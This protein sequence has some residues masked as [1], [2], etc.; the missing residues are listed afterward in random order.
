V[1]YDGAGAQTVAA[2][3]Y[4]YLRLTNT[5]NKTM[6][7]AVVVG[8]DLTIENASSLD[9]STGNFSL[10]VR[11]SWLVTSTDP[12]P[13]REQQGRVIFSGTTTTQT[14]SNPLLAET[15]YR[16]TFQGSSTL[17]PTYDATVDF[18]V[19]SAVTFTSGILQMNGYDLTL[20]MTGVNSIF[21][22]GKIIS[23][24]ATTDFIV[25]DPSTALLIGFGGTQFG[26]ATIGLTI[27]V[28]AGNIR[29]DGSRFYGVETFTKTGITRDDCNGGNVFYGSV[30]FNTVAGKERWR[31]AFLRPDTFYNASIIHFGISDLVF[32]YQTTGNTFYGN[33]AIFTNSP[34]GLF[35]TSN[36]GT[37]NG[38]CTFKGAVNV[39][40]ALSGQVNFAGGGGTITQ[41]C[42]FESTIRC[43][44]TGTSTGDVR[45]GG[46]NG[47]V[48]LTPTA[49]FIAGTVAGQ[50]QILLI[51]VTQNGTLM[52]TITTTGVNSL[53]SCG[54]GSIPS[55][56]N[57]PVTFTTRRLI[58]SAAFYNGDV[59]FIITDTT[60]LR[61]N[62]FNGL[63]NDITFTA[64]GNIGGSNGANRFAA[65][66][67]TTIR[68][69]SPVTF[70]W[71][72]FSPDDFNGDV[73]F[74]QTGSG[75]L[76]PAENT[77][78]PTTF[79]GNVSTLG[80]TAAVTFSRSKFDGSTTQ[81]IT[82]PIAFP[83]RFTN[84]E[85]ASTATLP[86]VSITVNN[87]VF[88]TGTV[89]LTSGTVDLNGNTLT[90]G[91][92]ANNT[93]TLVHTSGYFFNGTFRRWMNGSVLNMGSSRGLFPMGTDQNDY[94]PIWVAYS[95][96][97]N[98]GGILLVTHNANYPSLATAITPYTDA[99]WGNSVVGISNSNWRIALNNGF[100]LNGTSGSVRF[101]GDGFGT[102]ALA[103]LNASL[104]TTTVGTYSAA[105]NAVV[106]LEVTRTGLTTANLIRTWYI[107][108][109]NIAAS[110]LPVSWLDFTA[111]AGTNKVNLQWTT[112]SE[113][114][115][116]Y[117]LVQRS[118]DGVNFESIGTV[119][120]MG[121]SSTAQNY[122][123]IDTEPLNG[124]V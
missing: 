105:T 119:D 72:F 112:A 73:T 34:G 103:D 100:A 104:A 44:S 69:A 110:P 5:G 108:T 4:S 117:F 66:T 114:N 83:P 106:P 78:L 122:S 97:L 107:G 2:A 6:A 84:I 62:K 79:S 8:K 28:T 29:F 32:G 109:R 30:T 41:N 111:E 75:A 61:W 94:R 123:F 26:D 101:G 57:G 9:V 63:V 35:F 43:N 120:G 86:S 82:G 40:I 11:G 45:F 23:N 64:T 18:I 60:Q 36:V 7:G 14:I 89:R 59:T 87:V 52:Q 12:D 116:D 121:T 98:S 118:A 58:S 22:A 33:T 88:T 42:T 51:G 19:N 67:S 39:T 15:F 25:T 46:T 47:Y 24:A 96:T 70:A 48:T 49:N 113:L 92:A 93:G 16:V 10:T 77:S 71:G 76:L 1:N 90:M 124:L 38:E 37:T 55:T 99:S 56:F 95:S 85:I 31:M 21:T 68:N 20:T 13:F 17:N 3:T 53:I 54:V 65:G 81:T 74:I 115:N 27:D 50:T 80:S 102:Y 91:I